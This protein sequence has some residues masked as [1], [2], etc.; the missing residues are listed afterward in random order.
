MDLGL[1]GLW[2]RVFG[3]RGFGFMKGPLNWHRQLEYN[4]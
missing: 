4:D 3:L 2:L 1:M